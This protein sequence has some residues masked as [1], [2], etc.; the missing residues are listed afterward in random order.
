[1]VLVYLVATDLLSALIVFVTLPLIPLFMWLVGSAAQHRMDRRCA[2]VQRLSAYFLDVVEGLPDLRIFGRADAQ[3]ERIRAVTAAS[4]KATMGTLAIAFL[5]S[6]VLEILASISTALVAAVIGLRLV[7]GGMTLQTG[8]AVLIV[9]PEAYMPLRQLGTFF[10]SSK[11][12]MTAAS[13][14]LEIARSP[15]DSHATVGPLPDERQAGSRHNVSKPSRR[16]GA[17]LPRLL[18]PLGSS[19]MSKRAPDRPA[20]QQQ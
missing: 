6:M 20:P 10:H 13:T 17:A 18:N 11:E 12:G 8:L 14:V 7:E 3:V 1:L 19:S 15:A 2:L 9:V 4:R 5:S 16:A